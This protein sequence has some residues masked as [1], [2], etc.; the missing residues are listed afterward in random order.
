MERAAPHFL[1]DESC[2]PIVIRA[3]RSAGYDV[4]AVSEVMSRSDDRQLMMQA[5]NERRILLTADKDFGWLVFISGMESAGVILLRS[6]AR[7]R[8]LI[9]R[10]VVRVV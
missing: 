5:S 1:T 3:L 2:P 8:E 7:A 6:P 10:A 9:A 4:L